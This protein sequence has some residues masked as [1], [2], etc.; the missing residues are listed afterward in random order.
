MTSQLKIDYIELPAGDFDSVQNFYE[1]AFNWVFTDYGEQ[2]RAF[3][4]GNLNGGFYKSDLSSRTEN[5][6]ALIILRSHHLTATR[7]QIIAAGGTIKV[8]IF[9][10]PGGQRFQFTDPAG[11]ELAVWSD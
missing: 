6:A 11:N 10:F 7:D 8:D 1:Q 4:D 2:Y 5:G 3:S 9:S